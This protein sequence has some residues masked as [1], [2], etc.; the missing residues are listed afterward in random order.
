MEPWA[1]SWSNSRHAV[2]AI[3]SHVIHT[4]DE[5]IIQVMLRTSYRSAASAHEILGIA[6]D[7][8]ARVPIL[9]VM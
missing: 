2:T 3:D 9:Y 1:S 4:V 7:D 6:L 8:N 5:V